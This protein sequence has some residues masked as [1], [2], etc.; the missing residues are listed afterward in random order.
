M[1][2]KPRT[3]YSLFEEMNRSL[4]LPHIQRPFVWDEEQMRR[5]FDSLMRNYPIQTFLFWRTKDEI[6]ARKFMTSIDWDADL[7]EYYDEHTSAE[8]IDKVFVL[9]GQQRLQ[10]LFS[11][12]GGA[13][14]ASDGVSDLEAYVDITS[15]H[16]ADETGLL[17]RVSFEKARQPLPYFRLI[18]LLSRH[19]QKN[20]EE[21]ADELNDGLALLISESPEARRDRERLVRRN[22]SQLVSL[23]REEKH[24][25]VQQ[26][27]GVANEYPYRRI[28]DI[29]VRVNSGG[30]KLD[31]ADLMF[32]AMKE[33]WS[34]VEENI[35]D[36]VELLN[37]TNLGFDKS[38][39]LKCMVTAE[40]QGAEL[41][42]DKF[43]SSTGEALLRTIQEHWPQT[44]SAFQQLRDFIANELHL[45]GGKVVR[46]YSSFV[47][48]YDFLFH[49][50]RPSE[51][52]RAFMRAYYYKAQLFNW[53][54]AS[55]DSVINGMHRILGH[56]CDE[57]F[58][59]DDVKAY[60]NRFSAPTELLPD[61][62]K[63]SRLR[64]IV[65]NLI[66]VNSFGT[67]P[68]DVRFKGNEPHIDHVFPQSRLRRL[69]GLASDEINSLG[70]YR[71]VGATDNIRKRAE[72]PASYFGRLKAAGVDI[73]RHLILQD[74]SRDP[75]LLSFD[76]DTYRRFRNR[77]LQAIYRIAASVVNPELL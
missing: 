63:D 23:L 24:F 20:A 21:I 9:D 77:R 27:D 6:K 68:F 4:F 36:V 30:T 29:F 74:E 2:Y 1:S 39:V 12:F 59:L 60:F 26:L 52:D 28:L 43:T 5:L 51:T 45:Y 35:E 13:I 31:A 49:N 25:W 18:D 33:G 14:K 16:T 54:R 56:S 73:Q 67:S 22:C 48:L 50:P 3:L 19:D 72:E 75:N 40:G 58:P 42:P 17:Y 69:L 66:Y 37:G 41:S 34:E 8:G 7:H 71:F 57:G 47:P 64:F 61:H 11:L 62:L 46:S 44:E 53:Y 55:S 10:T 38:L 15:G 32:A 76:V 70:N 65:L